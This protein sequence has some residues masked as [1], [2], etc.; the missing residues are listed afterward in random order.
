MQTRTFA[1]SFFFFA[2]FR[3]PRPKRYTPQPGC[4]AQAERYR[5]CLNVVS[6]QHK[7]VKTKRIPVAD[8]RRVDASL[9]LALA[10]A[11]FF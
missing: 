11:V 6:G 9:S 10:L 2:L 7:R 5:R 8:Q 3:V 1:L 4:S